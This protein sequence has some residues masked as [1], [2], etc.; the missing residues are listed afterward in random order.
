MGLGLLPRFAEHMNMPALQAIVD[1]VLGL[2]QRRGSISADD[3]RAELRQV[4]V[5]D[6]RWEEVVALA[7]P[8]L[9]CRNG[10]YYYVASGLDRLRQRPLQTHQQTEV[11]RKAVRDMVRS[12]RVFSVD[13]ERRSERRIPFVQS[14]CVRLTDQ[15]GSDGM[16]FMTRDISVKGLRLVGGCSL[17]GQKVSIDVPSPGGGATAWTF[18]VQ[19]LW[20]SPVGNQIFESGGLFL[21]ANEMRGVT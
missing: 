16:R 13:A 18:L 6:S 4:G 19:I 14:V 10:E 7:Q 11:V 2:A 17:S 15:P 3:I 20:S 9:H 8:A 21:D 12:Y 5:P 1:S